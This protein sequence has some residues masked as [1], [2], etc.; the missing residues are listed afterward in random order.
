MT[1]RPFVLFVPLCLIVV[2]LAGCNVRVTE[3]LSDPDKAEP[4]KRLL[5]TWQWGLSRMEIDSPAVKG[6]PKRL[7]LMRIDSP[8]VKGHPKGL[9]RSVYNGFDPTGLW[10]FTTTIGKHTYGTI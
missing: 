8:A 6:N 9:M 2:L 10:F 3:P 4:D 7:G 1:H 5:G